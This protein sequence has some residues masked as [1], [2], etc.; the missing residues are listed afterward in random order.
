M[1]IEYCHLFFNC[2]INLNNHVKNDIFTGKTFIGSSHRVQKS[3]NN[4]AADVGYYMVRLASTKGAKNNRRERRQA[5][6]S[7]FSKQ[8]S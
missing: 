4:S 1:N 6:N 3:I 5:S 2:T 7:V 8:P